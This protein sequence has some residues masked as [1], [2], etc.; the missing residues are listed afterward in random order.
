MKYLRKTLLS[1][2]VFMLFIC[3]F[4]N[5]SIVPVNAQQR[6]SIKDSYDRVSKALEDL[7]KL[8][9]RKP[10]PYNIKS[11]DYLKKLI[12]D[13]LNQEMPP[14]K[15]KI[16]DRTLKIFGFVPESFKTRDFVINL[17]TSEVAGLYDYR[18]Q[19]LMIMKEQTANPQ[20]A[21]MQAYGMSTGDILLIHEMQHALQDQYFNLK[22]LLEDVKKNNND[23]YEF[24]VQ[25]LIEGDATSVMMLYAMSS[26]GSGLGVDMSQFIDLSTVGE[27]IADN[28]AFSAG[29]SPIFQTAPLY[30]RSTMLFPYINGM[31]FVESLRQR[32]GW[33]MVNAA[34]KNP[35]R[36]T[37]QVLHPEKY[38]QKDEPAAVQWTELPH[39][40]GGWRMIEQNTCGELIISVMFENMLPDGMDYKIPSAGWGGDRYRIYE[41]GGKHFLVWYTVWDR[42]QDAN[43]F[44]QYYI[45][46]LKR[47][48]PSVVWTNTT[49]RKAYLGRVGED[50][51]YIAINGKDVL[52]IEKCPPELTQAILKIAWYVNKSQWTPK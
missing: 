4:F 7:R 37:E 38:F 52:V 51:V 40:I 5:V 46:L 42:N 16:Y 39:S 47:K 29:S 17:Y 28:A 1:F 20:A 33:A 32:G 48:Y 35:P 45:N 30:Y 27:M 2:F 34:F 10:V 6:Y 23:D 15:F 8:K 22:K 12:T 24:A 41:K 11:R 21:L 31:A 18:T 9:F 25:A 50:H 43:E 13:L 36:S 19:S 49:P 26:M 44:L 14:E 3:I